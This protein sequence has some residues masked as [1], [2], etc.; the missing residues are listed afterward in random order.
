MKR[1]FVLPLILTLGAC[2]TQQ[3]R[4]I[5]T[6]TRDLRTV[7]R[8]IT[9]SEGTLRRGYAIEEYQTTRPTWRQCGWYPQRLRD[10]RVV[11]GAPRMCWDDE[12]ITRTRPRAVDLDVEQRKLTS[13][14]E[15]R[16]QLASAAGPAVQRCEAAFPEDQ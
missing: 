12:V 8:L 9:E 4:C 6:V 5:S 11:A 7:D 1:F 16:V 3:E 10:G 15:K 14:R 2:A 13:L